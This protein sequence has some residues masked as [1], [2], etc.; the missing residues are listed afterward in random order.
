MTTFALALSLLVTLPFLWVLARRPVL[1]RLALRNAARRPKEGLLVV[2]GSL[3]G[4][5]IIT[6]SFVVGDTVDGSIRQLA[7]QHLGPVDELVVGR[8]H[9]DWSQLRT[10]T[11]LVR[12]SNVDGVLPIATLDVAAVSGAPGELLTAPRS[13]VVMVDF[14][15]ARVFGRDPRATGVSGPTPRGEEA[16]VT[17]DLAKALN[18][19]VGSVVDVNAY[20]ATTHLVVDR[21]LPR[22]G[23]AGFSL[24]YEPE[25]RNIFVNPATFDLILQSAIRPGAPPQ[26]GVAISNRGGVEDGASLTQP[27]DQL[28]RTSTGVAGARILDVKKISLDAA[29]AQGKGFRDMFTA[30]GAF[31][32]LAGLLLLVNLFVML[33]A[34]RKG[35]LGMARAVGMRRSGLVGAFGTEGW[36]YATVA[37]F[38]GVALGIGLGRVIVL[39][40]QRIFSTQH[41]RVELFFTVRPGS[42]AVAFAIAYVVAVLSVVATSVRVSR[43]NIIRAIRDLAEPPPKRRRRSL[44]AGAL[45]V[46]LGAA[47]TLQ[48]APANEPDGLLLGPILALAG[49]APLLT[50]FAPRKSV[51]SVLALL[52]G[53]WGASMFALFPTAAE[54]ASI[55]AY[56]YQGV[57]LTGAGVVLVAQ[58]QELIAAALRRLGRGRR[59]ALRLGLAYPLARRS[60]T[61][62]TVAMYALVVFIL[63]F[64][65]SI[66]HMIGAQVDTAT[67]KVSGGFGVIVDS[68]PAN[69]V[70]ARALA[71]DSAVA[72]VAPLER[73]TAQITVPGVEPTLWKLTAFDRRLVAGG[74][75]TL[76]DRGS[77]PTDRAAWEAVLRNPRLVIADPAFKQTGGPPGFEL[78][79]GERAAIADPVTGARRVVRIAALGAYDN[80]IS[81]GFLYGAGGARSLFRDHLVRS[82]T[83]LGLRPGI[84]AD[85]FASSL[86]GRYVANGVEANSIRG[87]T[88]E[89]FAMTRQMFQLFEGYL[90]LGLVVG[91]A[92]LA[93]V[94][95]RA[96]RERRRQIG[97]LRA[98]GFG[99]RTVGRS[100]AIEAGFIAAEGTLLGVGL[101]LLTLYNIVTNTEAMG[102]LVFSV[103][104]LELGILLLFTIAA[105]LLATIG[106][107]LSA[108]R[109][110]PAGAL[111]RTD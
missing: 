52:A 98:I 40:C 50:R 96:V 82:R 70:S 29:D 7:R 37:S 46:L 104:Y 25:A 5:A 76:E 4:A 55:M 12:S 18:I 81:N 78:E 35:E 111:R 87:L 77:Y 100:F 36:L 47:W 105:S 2:V 24:G 80:F 88:E 44:L 65:T 64:I 13:Q 10:Q 110:R 73:T 20:G 62:L 94:M 59:L 54:G 71:R 56:V 101:A 14:R 79:V 89:A 92:G 6:G 16:A 51:F 86:Q 68:S 75:P 72:R 22:R 38:A 17:T 85:V 23:I 93:V 41:N 39:F 26:W 84:D 74:A 28:L 108:T 8:N 15:A 30:T 97:T 11:Q 3:L 53:A 49:L 66:S 21:V 95:V 34:E 67:Q 27:V 61:G 90:A 69:P 99:P 109:I 103:P 83:Y 43:L 48:A 107:A 19:G 57:A 31:G 91:I 9:G 1:R 45:A 63:T 60:R 42:I 106:P 102:E 33:A 58:Q 32:V